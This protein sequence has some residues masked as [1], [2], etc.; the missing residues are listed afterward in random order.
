M[1]RNEELSTLDVRKE[2]VNLVR[3]YCVF[4][5]LKMKDFVAEVLEDHLKEFKE[6]LHEMAKIKE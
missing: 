4:N 2:V 6:R 5:N 1:T 3:T